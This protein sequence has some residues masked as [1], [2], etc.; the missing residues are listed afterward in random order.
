MRFILV[1]ATLLL[2]LI[3][4]SGPVLAQ[5]PEV[6]VG[7][8]DFPERVWGTQRISFDVDNRTEYLKFIV[9]ESDITFEDSYA[10]ARRVKYSNFPLGPGMET[11]INPLLEIPGNYGKASCWIRLYDVVDTLDDISLGTKVFEQEFR[12]TFRPPES[13]LPYRQEGLT[14]PPLT[15][16]TYDWD[17]ELARLTVLLLNE[18]KRVEQIATMTGTTAQTVEDAVQRLVVGGHIRREPGGGLSLNVPVITIEEAKEGRAYADL[19]S[20][21]MVALVKKNLVGYPA[22]LDSLKAVGAFSGDSTNF[23]EGGALLYQ[24][25]PLVAAMLLWY[26]LGHRF[27]TD[28][29]KMM[30]Y[31]PNIMCTPNIGEFM[32][33]VEGAGYFNGTHYFN[34]IV[35]IRYHKVDFGDVVPAIECT[36][37]ARE[38]KGRTRK[39]EDWI[40]PPEFAPQSIVFDTGL[41]NPALRY[42]REGFPELLLPAVARLGEID[43]KY[44][45]DTLKRGV[46][47]WFWNLLATRTVDKL[48]KQGVLT[49]QGNGQFSLQSHDLN[50]KPGGKR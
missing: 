23:Y 7:K 39:G 6:T 42:L 37:A 34:P 46:K 49:R 22:F 25:Y 29:Q 27:I 1:T 50:R 33:L 5:D 43:K 48:V 15:G 21:E 30:I 40:I 35:N 28:G 8:I 47:F 44:G 2:S 31:R 16:G 3:I 14:V 17:N 26:D 12:L 41:V 13:I 32:Y 10:G 36:P 11:T 20:D 45:R 9:V 24:R 18:G 19:L 4:L 38:G